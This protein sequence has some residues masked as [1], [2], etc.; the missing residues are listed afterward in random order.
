[1]QAAEALVQPLPLV[2]PGRAR[3]VTREELEGRDE[4]AR[5]LGR[6]KEEAAGIA[7]KALSDAAEAVTRAA[8]DARQ[9]E[10]TRA[11][12]LFL[13]LR[14]EDERRAE[15][16]LD[17][18]VALARLLAERLLGHALELDPSVVASLA[19]QALAEARG[20]R[21]VAIRAHPLDVEPLRSHL[22]TVGI[23]GRSVDVRSDQSLSRGSLL[24]QTNLGTLDAQLAPQ[25]ERL[26]AALRD[27]LKSP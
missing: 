8:E 24:V 2:T 14:A 15:H 9:A 4:A 26:A 7:R 10:H 19:R 3:R 16:D 22:E 23:D 1:V 21:T 25:L 27:A 13:A 17:R 20:A 6:A 11:A 18:A 12:A 5:I